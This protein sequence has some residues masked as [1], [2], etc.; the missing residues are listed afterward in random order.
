MVKLRSLWPEQK[1]FFK[2]NHV[3]WAMNRVAIFLLNYSKNDFKA[4]W[5]NVVN[6]PESPIVYII[7]PKFI[8]NRASFTIFAFL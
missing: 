4:Q 5:N 7:L 6:L 2:R 1:V 3:I 8:R